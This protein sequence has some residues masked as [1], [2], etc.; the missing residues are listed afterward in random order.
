MQFANSEFAHQVIP[1]A[2]DILDGHVREI[3]TVSSP[4]F[5][6][7]RARP[8]AAVTASKGIGA[9][10]EESTGIDRLAG[11]DHVFPPT[12]GSILRRGRRVR[13][14]GQP[15][16]N[17]D[18]VIGFGGQLAPAF[19]GQRDLGQSVASPHVEAAGRQV[20]QPQGLR[21]LGG[22]A[23]SVFFVCHRPYPLGPSTPRWQVRFP[24]FDT[25]R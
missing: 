5:G 9:N 24:A 8:G 12:G 1:R 10:H 4:G 21:R 13:A 14:R 23:V 17:Q 7:D 20:A 22:K 2:G 6:I 18:C 11:P 25:A 19:V 16:E 15:G 3:G